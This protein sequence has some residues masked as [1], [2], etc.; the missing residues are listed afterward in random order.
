MTPR[1]T[2][3]AAL[4]AALVVPTL[5]AQAPQTASN[6]VVLKVNGE[7]IHAA[8]VSLMMQSVQQEVVR[9]GGQISNEDL[10][11]AATQRLIEQKMLAQEARRRGLEPDQER[12]EEVYQ[13]TIQRAGGLASLNEQLGRAGTSAQQLRDAFAEADLVRVLVDR[14]IRP[15]IRVSDEEIAKEFADNPDAFSFPERVKARHIVIA[16]KPEDGAETRA[17]ARAKAEAA[18]KRVLA[19]E[20]FAAVARE[21]SEDPAAA[22]GGDLGVFSR[23]MMVEPFANAAFALEPGQ[24]SEVV[25]TQFGFHV[26]KVEEKRAARAMTLDEVRPRL[27]EMLVTQQLT[28][29]IGQLIEQLRQKAA[30]VPVGGPAGGR[31]PGTS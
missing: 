7:S 18:R 24:V 23:D 4:I 13:Q 27:R 16:S 30:I 8:N 10:V 25:E 19:G 28:E 6:P 31:P 22:N 11:K 5:A 14:E 20:D 17:A 9:A 3:V 2:A 15:G 1:P 21:V 12:V 26:I 29:R